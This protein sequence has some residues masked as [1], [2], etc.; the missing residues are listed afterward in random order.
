M[1]LPAEQNASQEV[2][3][4]SLSEAESDM[5]AKG[6]EKIGSKSEALEPIKKET[7]AKV[8]EAATE[9]TQTTESW[10]SRTKAAFGRASNW[11]MNEAE[12]KKLDDQLAALKAGY[13]SAAQE[14]VSTTES[15][16][17]VVR[18]EN[19]EKRAE[20]KHEAAVLF[21]KLKGNASAQKMVEE[22]F[23]YKEKIGQVDEHGQIG[24]V[25]FDERL[26][27]IRVEYADGTS[28]RKFP[29][30]VV[31]RVLDG[32]QIETL[33]G[34]FVIKK[35]K[36]APD[37]KSVG[38]P[39]LAPEEPRLVPDWEKNSKLAEKGL[40]DLEAAKTTAE[41]RAFIVKE[42]LLP[43]EELAQLTDAEVDARRQDI[44]DEIAAVGGIVVEWIG[45]EQPSPGEQMRK[46]NQTLE[47]EASEAG[48]QEAIDRGV[49]ELNAE[50]NEKAEQKKR[51]ERLKR[52]DAPAPEGTPENPILLTPDMKKNKDVSDAMIVSE[53]P[54]W[55]RL[56]SEAESQ[57]KTL[58]QA[59]TD[60]EVKDFL[61]ENGFETADTLSRMSNDEIE[62]AR[63]AAW[64][65]IASKG[66]IVVGEKPPIPIQFGAPGEKLPGTK[67]P[68]RKIP[69][70]QEALGAKVQAEKAD[71]APMNAPVVE[72]GSKRVVLDDAARVEMLKN[73]MKA[74]AATAQEVPT[75]AKAETVK[76]LIDPKE[77]PLHPE[78]MPAI[79]EAL[80]TAGKKK[81]GK[82]ATPAGFRD[83]LA[84]AGFKLPETLESEDIK[85]LH[86][87]YKKAA[88][89]K[90]KS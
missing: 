37:L 48:V 77:N 24:D 6:R 90:K 53:A 84:E 82:F 68:T 9:F 34:P 29:S 74:P 16:K 71:T 64:E 60:A 10:W 38:K 69:G 51:R 58:G 19:V 14:V 20:A 83:A 67:T 4:K 26:G 35:P 79:V 47:A 61:Q 65:A 43:A 2:E 49:A 72:S 73:L 13:Q 30:G 54:D 17:M 33:E 44:K 59:R 63:N 22:L 45:A 23:T 21:E 80:K 36:P 85:N 11:V 25:Q 12:I 76:N 56:T 15:G 8:E 86:N 81:D 70:L 75:A 3:K 78:A 42:K 46:A 7:D 18:D 55:K 40:K 57:L 27:Q 52:G 66:G 31:L 87:A 28:L 5:F 62:N 88:H 50:N 89:G 1:A 32:G 41:L 39:P